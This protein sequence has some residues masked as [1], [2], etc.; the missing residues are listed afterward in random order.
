MAT[1]E[2]RRG[3]LR[4]AEVFEQQARDHEQRANSHGASGNYSLVK[5]ERAKA[6]NARASAQNHRRLAEEG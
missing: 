1:E 6:A 5:I 3:H 2:E 4:L